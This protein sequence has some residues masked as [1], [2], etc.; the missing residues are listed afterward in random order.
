MQV[1]DY[2]RDDCAALYEAFRDQA[3][4]DATV[5]FVIDH[6][7]PMKVLDLVEYA[8]LRPDTNEGDDD[9]FNLCLALLVNLLDRH[10]AQT[11]KR[12]VV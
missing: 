8:Y 2:T 6:C 4:R 10:H 7:P 5:D 3:R 11:P 9:G 1:L 12:E